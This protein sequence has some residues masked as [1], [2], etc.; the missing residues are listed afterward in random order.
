MSLTGAAERA[1]RD[2]WARDGLEVFRGSILLRIGIFSNCY[3]PVINGVVR[4]ISV[5]REEL[6]RQ[7]HTV[8]VF[9][10]RA[11]G[12]KDVEPGVLRYSAVEVR[13]PAVFALPIPFSR[14]IS[15]LIPQ[16]RLDIIHSQHPV[17]LGQEAA[18]QA[19]RLG[20][21]LVFTYH[22]RYEA[23]APYIPFNQRVVKSLTREVVGGYL[24]RCQRIIVPS[25][26]VLTLIGEEYP[27]V[28]R[29]AVVIPT[30]VDLR[31]YE[32]LDPAPIRARYR[33]GDDFI[34]VVVTRLA[35]EKGLKALL[36][37]FALLLRERPE[38]RLLMVGDGPLHGYLMKQTAV[39]GI[40]SRVI[41]AEAVPFEQVPQYLAAGDAFVYASLNETQGLAIAEAMAAGLPVVA[42]DATGVRDTI[43]NGVSGLLTP[44]D[45]VAL[46]EGMRRL[47][48]DSMLRAR[49]SAGARAA[50]ARYAVPAITQKLLKVYE[51]A[52]AEARASG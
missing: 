19:R 48:D 35:L 6:I 11:R 23:Y 9:A 39:L 18:H 27:K 7:Q 20:V 8:Y 50:A 34:F 16:L 25:E 47:M 24:E 51:E 17:A 10:P 14:S 13:Y 32:H 33:L 36:R 38:A 2:A 1:T 15:K 5:F 3:Q 45:E 42:M 37:A 40:A 30:P 43:T 41:F 29:R 52:I 28:V 44:P 22:S 12:Y 46:A 26:S 49:L 31:A 4:S 21:P